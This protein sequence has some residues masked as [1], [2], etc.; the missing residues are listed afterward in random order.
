MLLVVCHYIRFSACSTCKIKP[1][2]MLNA[3]VDMASTGGGL[4]DDSI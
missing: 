1:G 3:G 2:S 4:T